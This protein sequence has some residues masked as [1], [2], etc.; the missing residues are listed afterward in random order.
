MSEAGERM[1]AGAGEALR[2]A[3]KANA[4]S[5]EYD[6]EAYRDVLRIYYLPLKLWSQGFLYKQIAAKLN[7][8]EGTVRS[9]VYRGRKLLELQHADDD[10]A[11][12]LYNAY[13]A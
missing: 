1:L 8:P 11:L 9:R 13:T 12:A 6:L 3:R 2:M 4:R 7:I 10:R 5:L